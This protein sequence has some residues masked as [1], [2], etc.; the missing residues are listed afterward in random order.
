M[1]KATS[2][3]CFPDIWNWKKCLEKV[4]EYD[5]YGIEINFDGDKGFT[6]DISIDDLK[7]VK[8][9]AEE[10]GIKIVSVY[11]RQQWKT[12]ISSRDKEKREKGIKTIEKLIEI[13]EFFEAPT[14]LTIPG[15]VDN[16]ILSEEVEILPYDEVYERVK[17]ILSELSILA[18]KKGVIL[19]VENV[20][21]KFLLSPLEFKKFIEE[22]NSK[23]VGIHFDVANCLYYYGVP[24]DWIRILGNHI[25]AVHIKDFKL[26]VGN[27]NGFCNI[28][29]GD[30]NWKNV[31]SAFAEIKYDG[32]MINEVLPPVKF[33]NTA[34]LKGISF[35]MEKFIKEIEKRKTQKG[36]F[37]E[38]IQRKQGLN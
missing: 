13:A 16:S 26:S 29:E 27:I 36:L 20:P 37:D 14:I 3:R 9:K 35:S 4:R 11:S 15:A 32:A 38:K 5:F 8:K 6:L 17:E 33:Y 1:I 28:F 31:C 30:I 12:P 34:S 18:E 22:I 25:K 21:N 7:K 24:E 10:I 19:A 2:L 23:A